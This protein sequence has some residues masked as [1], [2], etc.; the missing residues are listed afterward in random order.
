MSAPAQSALI[1]GATG[2]TGKHLLAQLLASPHFSRVGEYG[3]RVSSLEGRE[4]E[5]ARGKLEQKV[6]DFENLGESGMKEGKWD[7]VFVTLGTTR[8]SAGS[9]AAFEKIDREYVVNAAKEA[10]TDDPEHKQRIV[11][12]SSSGA[13]A[14]SPFLYPRSKGLTELALARLGYADTIVFQPGFL[15][16]AERPD[17]RVA[18]T[19]FG[20]ITGAMSH[21]SPSVEIEVPLLA[22]SILDAGRLGTSS[23]PASIGATKAGADNAWYTI[24][25]NRGAG[26]LGRE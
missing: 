9:A 14:S 13:N 23:L 25:G 17:K 12:L 18:E 16:G 20:Y 4:S 24:I 11:Y 10:K 22:K 1:L 7:V 15:R 26:V 6:I 5:A 8:A 2:A 19:V 3:R 21:F